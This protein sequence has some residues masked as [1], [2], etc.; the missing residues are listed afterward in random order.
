MKGLSSS[1]SHHHVVSYEP[2]YDLLGHNVDRKPYLISQN[3]M[4]VPIPMPHS[5]ELAY[6]NAQRSPYPSD[7]NSIVPYGTFPRRCHSTSSSHHPEVK[8]EGLAMVPYVG[9]GGGGGGG[10]GYGGKTPTRVPANFADPFERQQSFSRDG[11]HTLQ[12]KRGVLAHSGGMGANNINND[13]PGRIRHLVHSVQ[14]LFTKSHSLEGPHH[15]QS[16]KGA[17]NG[18]VNG[19]VGGGGGGGGGSRASLEGETPPGGVRHRK[20]SK[21]RERCRSAE[22]K[23]RSHHHH[24]HQLHGSAS[25]PGSGYWSSDDNLE[26]ELCLY[27][28]HHHQ[29]PPSPS[30]SPSPIAMTMGRYP[31]RNH[32]K[33]PQSP[34][35]NLSSSQSQQYF[36]MDPYGTLNEHTHT[37]AHHGHTHHHSALKVSRSNNDVKYTA[38]SACVPVSGSSNNS[39][40]GIVGGSG[41]LLP[42]GL[43]D[44]PL[45]KK[46]VW[47]SSLTVSRAREVYTNNSSHNQLRASAG[48]GNL[49]LDRALVK[50]R[51]SQQQERTCHFLQDVK[52]LNQKSKDWK[53][54]PPIPM[55]RNNHR[56]VKEI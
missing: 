27:H 14:K 33:Y 23:H 48:P 45:V 20:R 43:V 8:D 50:S 32:D 22:P 39:G 11:Y 18:S 29:P 26:R 7:S 17:N 12:Y 37:H 47:S 1:R 3:D 52:W 16:N 56:C 55:G 25:A 46:G 40:G 9:G 13:S 44:G 34:L 41:S 19:G 35:P 10:G 21:S 42:L 24:H 28:P 15:T 36:M 2:S 5:A 51:G 6:Y 54:A 53:F 31:G 49:N 30:M 38:S 4:P